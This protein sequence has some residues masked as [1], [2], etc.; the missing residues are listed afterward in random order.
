MLFAAL[1]LSTG[2]AIALAAVLLTLVSMAG[3]VG[4]WM[5]RVVAE[6]VAMRT[7]LEGMKDDHDSLEARVD[8]HEERLTG[9]D[10]EIVEIRE[11]VCVMED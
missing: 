11:R 3:G 8:R 7:L 5:Y 4:Y 6:L 9:H 2:D 10:R 1:S